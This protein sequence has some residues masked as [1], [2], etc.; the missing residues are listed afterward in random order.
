[1]SFGM[2]CVLST[3]YNLKYL[4]L[5]HGLPAKQILKN[6]VLL[7]KLCT[8]SKIVTAKYTGLLWFLLSYPHLSAFLSL[9]FKYSPVYVPN[10][11]HHLPWGIDAA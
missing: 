2:Q 4:L 6:L 7:T 9:V 11:F 8:S 1:M 3:L 5:V 10:W